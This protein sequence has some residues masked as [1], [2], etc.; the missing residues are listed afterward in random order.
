MKK[1]LWTSLVIFFTAI[2]ISYAQAPPS[3]SPEIK[4]TL[5][6]TFGTK[7]VWRGFNVYGER[8][9][10][11]PS[12]DL[13]SPDLNF[14]FNLTAHK[15]NGSGYE[16]LER[17]D[18]NFYYLAKFFAEEQQEIDLRFD[19]V[20]YNYPNQS[21][22]V[23]GKSP[24]DYS[25]PTSFPADEGSY[26]LQELNM[27]MSLPKLLQIDGLVPSYVLVKLWPSNSGTVVGARSPTGGTASGFAH[28]F[29]LDYAM[30]YICPF[31]GVDRKLNWHAEVV[32]NDG[33]APD[34]GGNR[35]I[36]DHD[37]SDG[38]L[39]ATTSYEL[40]QNLFLTPGL[41]FQSSWE[42]T[43]NKHDQTW[44]TLSLTYKF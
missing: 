33:V 25:P 30:P 23:R 32:Y 43:V 28:I 29:M 20:Y 44:G 12:V 17:W 24:L 18:Y 35:G 16:A 31:T 41:F 22:H 40:V 9:A 2:T 11:H 34:G 14:G 38:V 19:Y 42:D 37:W 3:A 7:Y 27:V 15:A 1:F 8:S 39:G 6:F 36:T 5:D 13:F 21:G 10:I 26:D 4:G